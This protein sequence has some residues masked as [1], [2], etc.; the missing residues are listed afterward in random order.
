MAPGGHWDRR[1]ADGRAGV[2]VAVE[3]FRAAVWP[4]RIAAHS[5]P[6]PVSM[7]N[8]AHQLDGRPGPLGRHGS[9]KHLRWRRRR[10]THLP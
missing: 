6:Q 9:A 10:T 3:A 4:T 5:G 8:S 1:D 2:R 7:S